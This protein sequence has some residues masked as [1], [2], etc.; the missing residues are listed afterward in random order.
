MHVSNPTVTGIVDRLEKSGYV[1]RVP[2]EKDRRV[3]N[4]IITNKGKTMAKTFLNNVTKKWE[5]LLGHLPKKDQESWLRIFKN[6]IE[7]V[8]KNV[9]P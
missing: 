5:L 7:G 3:T 9:N 4:I 8:G 2:D 6:I 1:K